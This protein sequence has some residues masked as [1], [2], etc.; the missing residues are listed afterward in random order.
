M[1]M[2]YLVTLEVKVKSK[3]RSIISYKVKISHNS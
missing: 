3:F 2:P 1:Y